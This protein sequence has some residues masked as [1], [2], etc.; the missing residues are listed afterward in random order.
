MIKTS[1]NRVSVLLAC[2]ILLTSCDDMD[3]QREFEQEAMAE[4]S[5]ITQTDNQG[6]VLEE[7]PDDWRISPMFGASIDVEYPAY[8][9][10]TDGEN[11]TIALRFSGTDVVSGLQVF[12]YYQ[13]REFRE[14][15]YY[16]SDI[17]LFKDI[18]F[19]P[20]RLDP[21][22][23]LDEARGLHRVFIY[24]LNENLITYGDIKVE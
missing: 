3:D 22:G 16:D 18:V 24:D 9:N 8:P 10:P 12:S 4:P 20:R 17:H 5:G 23:V 13:E 7:D 21:S 15:Y 6:E 19:D 11:V 1:F 14:I 2:S